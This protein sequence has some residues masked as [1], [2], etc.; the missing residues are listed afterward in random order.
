MVRTQRDDGQAVMLL[1]SAVALASVS[2]AALGHFAVRVVDRGRS[3]TAADAA[4]LAGAEG[5][6]AAASRLAMRNGAT[7]VEFAQ[8]G[9]VVTVV[10]A[11][12]GERA[13]AA[14]TIRP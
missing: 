4:A 11:V 14:A 8:V 13:R 12:G 2:I 7:L 6:R 3:Q 9:D 10:V 5:G 1:L